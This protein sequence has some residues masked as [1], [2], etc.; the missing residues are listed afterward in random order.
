M[1]T[2]TTRSLASS[3]ISFISVF[4]SRPVMVCFIGRNDVL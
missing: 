1:C 3:T 2:P 4:S